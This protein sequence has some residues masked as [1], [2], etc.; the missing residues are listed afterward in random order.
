MKNLIS[1]L[2][3]STILS[4]CSK[5]T[6]V[7][8][9]AGNDQLP[10]ETQT[11]ANTVGCL[12]NGKVFLPKAEGINPEVNCFY[13]LVN[14]EYFFTMAFSD[15]RGAGNL[16]TSVQTSR[17]ILQVGETYILNK[18][19]IDNG[20]YTGA[21]AG[22]LT[23]VNNIYRTNSTVTGELKITK[24]DPSNSIISGIFWFDAKNVIGEIVE[25]RQGRF[26]WR[27]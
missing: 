6:N 19:T 4:C 25:I 2:I 5:D 9:N 1:I 7:L 15:M 8:G 26:D 23:S 27:Y 13:Q 22:Y 20:D 16:T 11:G 18:N 14:G 10:P 3:I 17:V 12:V 24:L 21:G